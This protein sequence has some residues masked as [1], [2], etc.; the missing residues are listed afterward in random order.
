M[1]AN[2][3]VDQLA[4]EYVLG[5]LT[6]QERR[7]VQQRLLHDKDLAH[8]VDQWEARL[9][10]LAS[11]APPLQPST[12]LWHR[13]AASVGYRSVEKTVPSPSIAVRWLNS[14]PFWRGL[15]FAGVCAAVVMATTLVLSP[16]TPQYLVVLAAPQSQTP[17]WLVRA[18]TQNMVELVPLMVTPV[19]AGQTLQFW[20]K[21]DGWNA[22]VSLGLVEPGKTIRIPLEQL[23]PL[24]T[25]QLFEL[26]L[27]QAGGSP[28]GL[29]TGPIQFIGR[30]VHV[31]M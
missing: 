24:E 13:I 1:S 6:A 18:S 20:T 15:S 10:P 17:G 27:E 3:T 30:T 2:E 29:P 31:D 21:A 9:L 4:S 5:T 26:T 28:T 8:A 14:L 11:I 25:N 19:P 22:P 12:A 23:P 16:T 7:E